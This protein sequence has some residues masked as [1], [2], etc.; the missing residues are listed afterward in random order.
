MM[1]FNIGERV[2]LALGND[3]WMNGTICGH[4]FMQS[5]HSVT[6]H[7]VYHIRLDNGQW[8]SDYA[9]FINVVVAHPEN[10]HEIGEE[11]NG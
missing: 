3:K 11:G 6:L 5:E 1:M 8:T 7:P 4:G 9:A 10:V 2:S